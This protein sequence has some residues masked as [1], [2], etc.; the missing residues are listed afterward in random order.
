MERRLEIE[1]KSFFLDFPL[2]KFF[3]DKV[4]NLSSFSKSLAA[5]FAAIF[6]LD[7]FK[8]FISTAMTTL[9]NTN[10]AASTNVT[11]NRGAVYLLMQQYLSHSASEEHLERSVSWQEK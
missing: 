11:K 3:A 10:W 9:T 2:M 8:C 6:S 7:S 1:G 5:M 4:N